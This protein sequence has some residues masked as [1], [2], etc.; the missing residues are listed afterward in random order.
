MFA[1]VPAGVAMPPISGPNAVAIITARPMLLSLW[2]KSGVVEEA[3][4]KRQEHR[5]DR[6]VRDPPRDERTSDQQSEEHAVHARPDR[7]SR[8]DTRAACR[9]RSG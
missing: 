6:H 3:D 8:S 4:A 1:A 9:G 5:R 7:I 2:P